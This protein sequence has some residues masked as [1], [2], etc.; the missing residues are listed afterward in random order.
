MVSGKKVSVPNE[1]DTDSQKEKTA[2][3]NVIYLGCSPE[4][5]ETMTP[6][7]LLK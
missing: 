2:V 1:N 7:K 5:I 3:Q 6:L 4:R